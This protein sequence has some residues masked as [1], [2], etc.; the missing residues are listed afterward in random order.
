MKFSPKITELLGDFDPSAPPPKIDPVPNGVNRPRWSVM[1]PTFNCAEYLKQ[2]LASVL[3]QDP[4]PDLM[5]IEVIDDCSTKDDPEAVV[6]E[7]GKGRVAFYRK[8]KNEGAIPNF[9]TCIERSRGELVHILHG[10]DFVFPGFYRCLEDLSQK[11]PQ[12]S[13][14]ATRV[15]FV[16]EE[17]HW[18]GMTER[19]PELEKGANDASAFVHGTPLQFAGVAIRRSFYEQSG[20]FR[21]ELI[22]TADWE[23]WMRAIKAGKGCV[24]SHV[25]AGYRVFA[26]NDTGRLM[27]TAENLID[28]LRLIVLQGN[29]NEDFPVASAFKKLIKVGYTQHMIFLESGDEEAAKINEK[30]WKKIGGLSGRYQVL[31]YQIKNLLKKFA[32]KIKKIDSN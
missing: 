24:S 22:H 2:T 6:R 27:R 23:M 28:R 15:V 14:L 9:N 1:I 10:D 32:Q 7:M 31:G 8:E 3:A 4:G 11:N 19:I 17:G 21:N 5:Q 13:L 16:N 30:T 18:T 25:L 26:T 12:A 29:Q 20:G